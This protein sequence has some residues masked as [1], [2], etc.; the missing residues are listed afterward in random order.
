MKHKEINLILIADRFGFADSVSLSVL[1]L[2]FLLV[3]Q[4][5]LHGFCLIFHEF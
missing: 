5:I 1:F 2:S 3:C 4:M